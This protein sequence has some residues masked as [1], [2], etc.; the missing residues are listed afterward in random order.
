MATPTH[1]DAEL[2]LKLYDARREPEIRKARQ[3]WT[4]DFWPESADDI[5][6]IAR[7]RAPRKM[8]GCV[9]SSVTGA[10]PDLSSP[11]ACLNEDLFLRTEL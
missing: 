3:W 1:A 8:P 7:S 5:V 10:W 9:R 6:K 2:I 11:T 4:A